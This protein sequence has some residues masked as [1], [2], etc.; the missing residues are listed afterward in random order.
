MRIAKHRVLGLR[1]VGLPES[2]ASGI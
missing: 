2:L 1:R